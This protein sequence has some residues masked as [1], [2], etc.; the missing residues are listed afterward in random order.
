MNQL[1]VLIMVLLVITVTGFLVAK[2]FNSITENFHAPIETA[3]KK[4]T[5]W[6]KDDSGWWQCGEWEEGGFNL[7]LPNDWHMRANKKLLANQ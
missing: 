2:H 6:I 3:Y 7:L 5:D 1:V 4:C